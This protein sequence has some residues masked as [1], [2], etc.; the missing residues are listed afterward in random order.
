VIRFAAFIITGS[1]GD[2]THRIAIFFL[3]LTILLPFSSLGFELKHLKTFEGAGAPKAV[4]ISPDG[5]Y[6]AIMNLEGMDFWLISTA[7]LEIIKKGQFF[8]T[9]AQ[10]W[11]YKARE[12][13]QSYAQK[14]VEC[15]FSENGRLLW[16]SL[17]NAEAVTIYDTADTLVPPDQ[18]PCERVRITDFINQRSYE[19]RIIKI[20]TGKTPKVIR[21]TPDGRYALVANWHSSSVSVVDTRQYAAIK[22]I[23][24]GG[25]RGWYIPR[26]IAVSADSTR[27]YV[28]NMGGGTI[29][30]IDLTTLEVID[31]I[32]ATA[33]PRHIILSKD[34]RT[35]Y[36][37]DNINGKILAFDLVAKKTMREVS[38]GKMARTIALTPDE[39]YLFAVSHDEGK[40]V[41]VDTGSFN[42]IYKKD[43]PFPMGLAVSPDGKQ[44]WVTS[45]QMGK[46][47]VYEIVR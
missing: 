19:Q 44:L 5:S 15:A 36:I 35:L 37:S 9:P 26:G 34:Q 12:P 22:A 39:K 20:K 11:D 29:S 32:P 28:A 4:E 38:I 18:A 45:Y 46:I 43:F 27:A 14:P 47:G 16:I 13:I 25:K 3:S 7:S 10:G 40:L 1:R 2:M 8:R 31:D 41:V 23:R 24:L 21:V 30:V 33:N 6:A 17:H 42:I